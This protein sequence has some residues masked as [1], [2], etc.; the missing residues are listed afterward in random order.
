MLNITTKETH[1][2]RRFILLLGPIYTR[3]HGQCST[4]IHHSYWC[5]SWNQPQGLYTRSQGLNRKKSFSICPKLLINAELYGLVIG[6]KA[7]K[8]IW[9]NLGG[10]F[11]TLGA[12]VSAFINDFGPICNPKMLKVGLKF[13]LALT[14]S[15][16]Q[17]LRGGYP[18]PN[19]R[20]SMLNITT[21][22]DHSRS[23]RRD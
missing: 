20:F 23:W 17:A 18:S 14:P 6:P 11:A 4:Q 21:K 12:N 15:V 8:R 5:K 3:S 1:S 7:E 9:S 10:Q 19:L 16:K 2:R 13:F 22:E